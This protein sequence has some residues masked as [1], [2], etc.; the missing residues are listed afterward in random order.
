MTEDFLFLV[1]QSSVQSENEHT[2]TADDADPTLV[3]LHPT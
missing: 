1:D 2:G 3:F